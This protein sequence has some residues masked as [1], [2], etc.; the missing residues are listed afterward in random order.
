[1]TYNRILLTLLRVLLGVVL[2]SEVTFRATYHQEEEFPVIQSGLDS[3]NTSF[4]DDPFFQYLGTGNFWWNFA[5]IMS[6]SLPIEPLHCSGKF[7]KSFFFPGMLSLAIFPSD[8]PP[9]DDS[10]SP[11]ATT[12]M[13]KNAPGYQFE[14]YPIDENQDPPMT[15]D[16]C[17]VFGIP[18]VALQLCLKKTN[19][20]SLIAGKSYNSRELLIHIA[21]NPCPIDVAEETSCLNDTEWQLVA[22][23]NTKMTISKR[24]AS[25]IFDRANLTLIDVKDL[26]P[27]IPMVYEPED[28]FAIYEALLSVNLTSPDWDQSTPFSLLFTVITFLQ[29]KINPQIR[30]TGTL[31]Q[32]QLEQFLA[33]PIVIFCDAWLGRLVSDLDMGKS[34]VLTASSYRV[35]S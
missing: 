2:L 15:L 11:S 33:T 20:S 21:W 24:Y 5:S 17:Q 4:V 8:A 14:F 12:I 6:Y 16:D 7:C 25:A 18:I 3:M 22:P 10:D 23:I 32:I 28:L 31:P 13:Q 26:S 1:M 27:P 30:S 35:L 9:I 19:E 34:L 29:N